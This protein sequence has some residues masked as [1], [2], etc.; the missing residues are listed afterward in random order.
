MNEIDVKKWVQ[1]GPTP[2]LLTEA[3]NFGKILA[4]QKLST[5][6]IRQVFTKLK[7]IEAKGYM[8]QKIDFMMLKPFLAYAAGR[9]KKNAGLHE[10]KKTMTYG[11]EAVI[12]ENQ[13]QEEKRFNHFCKLFEAVLAYHRAHGGN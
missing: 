12:K 6:Q 1:S 13:P 8:N 5:S 2:A 11:I 10:F 7:A 3:E 4:G 9:D